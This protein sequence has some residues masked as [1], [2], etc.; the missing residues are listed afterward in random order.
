MGDDNRRVIS[1]G[2]LLTAIGLTMLWLMNFRQDDELRQLRIAV[3]QYQR[4]ME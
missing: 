2:F 4:G 3:Q 1:I